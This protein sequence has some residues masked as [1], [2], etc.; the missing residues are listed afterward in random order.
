MQE[1]I[2]LIGTTGDRVREGRE[3]ENELVESVQ[4]IDDKH[5]FASC[6][7]FIVFQQNHIAYK[8]WS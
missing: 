4:Q 6:L 8:G 2:G 3:R 7:F 1:T 5:R